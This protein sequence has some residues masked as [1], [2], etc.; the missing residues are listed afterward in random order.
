MRSHVAHV[1][2]RYRCCKAIILMFGILIMICAIIAGFLIV[3]F[4]DKK[5]H[6]GVLDV[7]LLNPQ[8]LSSEDWSKYLNQS[9]NQDYYIFNLTN[10][11]DVLQNGN[12]Y[13]ISIL[14]F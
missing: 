11:K 8:V 4:V 10:L 1:G 12:I 2:S 6:D 7:L 3:P 5:Q 9:T 13:I 14:L